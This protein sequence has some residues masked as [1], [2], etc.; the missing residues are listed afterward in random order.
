[1]VIKLMIYSVKKVIIKGKYHQFMFIHLDITVVIQHYKYI[2]L[3]FYVRY[4]K[5]VL[6]T[7]RFKATIIN[8]L[9]SYLT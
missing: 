7:K 6:H 2:F 8:S 3:L 9:V 5:P 1:M 4:L